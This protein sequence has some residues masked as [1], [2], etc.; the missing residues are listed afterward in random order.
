MPIRVTCPESAHL[1]TVELAHG[2]RG[3]RVL[4]CS[5]YGECAVSCEETCAARL[6][7]KHQGLP[8]GTLLFARSMF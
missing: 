3:L 8:P 2:R 5:A 1:E 6:Q 7:R 4:R